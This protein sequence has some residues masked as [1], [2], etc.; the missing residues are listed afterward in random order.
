[1]IDSFD[2]VHRYLSN[3]FLTQVTFEDE[4][5]DSVEAAFQAAKTLS[6]SQ[7]RII[8]GAATP[9]RAKRL[10]R[11]IALREDWEDIKH[12]VMGQ[13]ILQKFRRHDHLRTRLLS[14]GDEELIEGNTWHDNVWGDCRCSSCAETPGENWLG[15]LLMAV[16]EELSPYKP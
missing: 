5:Y 6:V 15:R 2:G 4:E 16:R 14:T 11:S 1:M 3:F 7:R 9:G 10:G 13:L 8:A 12:G